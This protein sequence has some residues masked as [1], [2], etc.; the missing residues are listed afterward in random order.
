MDQTYFSQQKEKGLL[1]SS[2]GRYK[3]ADDLFLQIY[4]EAKKLSQKVFM[5]DILY[6]RG[7][8]FYVAHQLQRAREIFEKLARFSK[9]FYPGGM[10]KALTG[11]G[12]VDL[13]QGKLEKALDNFRRGLDLSKMRG[14][15]LGE[16]YANIGIV[17][18][19]MGRFKDALQYL[20]LAKDIFRHKETIEAQINAGRI[21]QHMAGIH[22]DRGEWE[23]ALKLTKK[24]VQLR[25]EFSPNLLGLAL[26][27]LARCHKA[28]GQRNEAY[29]VINKAIK[30]EESLDI[31]NVKPLLFLAELFIEDER[32]EEAKTVLEKAE[33]VV[34]RTASEPEG[35]LCKIT[36]G[37]YIEKVSTKTI[38]LDK[39]KIER[40]YNLY[41][42]ALEKAQ[43]LGLIKEIL[44]A[45][46]ELAR[47]DIITGDFKGAE[48]FLK[49]IQEPAYQQNLTL[50]HIKALVL[51]A[52]NL[53]AQFNFPEALKLLES[54]KNAA[55]ET[56]IS[57]IILK[58][59]NVLDQISEAIQAAERYSSVSDFQNSIEGRNHQEAALNQ[60]NTYI[61]TL[62]E[63]L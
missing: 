27:D 19:A 20:S 37:K 1:L 48:V 55:I 59:K 22:I 15:C 5:G 49:A 45:N 29:N 23:K 28:M 63:K 26:L 47:L 43:E 4:R 2:Q 30:H 18:R 40:A 44:L 31:E 7:W 34:T 13:A 25:E 60:F 33:E 56:G 39:K 50:I 58:I 16:F 21:I 24:H 10:I 3:E 32:I 51:R 8:N 14:E 6:E 11:K 52:L 38:F 61:Y 17:Y 9:S 57:S 12:L 35:I 46:L 41:Q 36:R 54:A 53:S 42:Q 62:R